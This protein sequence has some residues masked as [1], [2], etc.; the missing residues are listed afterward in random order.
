M[1]TLL[2]QGEPIQGE[3]LICIFS[4]ITHVQIEHLYLWNGRYCSVSFNKKLLA[5]Y[6]DNHGT[7]NFE[8][9]PIRI[10]L[11][12]GNYIADDNSRYYKVAITNFYH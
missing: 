8:L 9:L 3:N 1:I 7:I 6:V 11:K 12:F 10:K 5:D 2:P 4:G